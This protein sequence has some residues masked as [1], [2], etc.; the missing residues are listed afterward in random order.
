MKREELEITAM[1]DTSL[2]KEKEKD[3]IKLRLQGLTF[4]KIGEEL[5][6]TT[7]HCSQLYKKALRFV[8]IQEERTTLESFIYRNANERF[9]GTEIIKYLRYYGIDTMEKLDKASMEDISRIRH[10]GDK[11]MTVIEKAKEE[12]SKC[13]NKALKE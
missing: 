7:W 13:K 11:S 2:L 8:K 10:I 9:V 3:V 5:G 12:Y 1:P 6:M 4:S